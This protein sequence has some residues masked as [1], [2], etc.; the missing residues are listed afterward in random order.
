ML[1]NGK[2]GPKCYYILEMPRDNKS[3][4]ER[5]QTFTQFY[6]KKYFHQEMLQKLRSP[7][8]AMSDEVQNLAFLIFNKTCKHSTGKSFA[9]Q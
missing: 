9:G 1:E 5:I 7:K 8:E 3:S 4:K 6:A 2:D